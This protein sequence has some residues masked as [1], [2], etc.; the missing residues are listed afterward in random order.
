MMGVSISEA[1]DLT[2]WKYQALLWNWND[3]HKTEDVEEVEAPDMDAVM[4]HFAR[5]ERS[6]L[7]KGSVH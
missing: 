1:E 3:R 2:W 5:L 4:L 7:V 6:G